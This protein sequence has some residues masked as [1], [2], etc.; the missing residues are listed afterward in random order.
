MSSLTARPYGQKVDRSPLCQRSR[1]PGVAR[2]QPFSR[3]ARER[4][5]D[6]ALR[7]IGL[8]A[9]IHVAVAIGDTLLPV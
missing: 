2:S 9:L 1:S 4:G 3:W 5:V 8:P 6:A 7:I